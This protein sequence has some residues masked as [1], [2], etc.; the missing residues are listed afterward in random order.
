MNRRL[1][2]TEVQQ[3]NIGTSVTFEIPNLPGYRSIIPVIGNA[4]NTAV[5][6]LVIFSGDGNEASINVV[7][8]SNISPT[9]IIS[10]NQLTINGLSQKIQVVN[11]NGQ[12]SSSGA[13]TVSTSVKSANAF[14]LS[15]VSNVFATPYSVTIEFVNKVQGTIS[16]RIRNMGDN[17]AVVNTE[18]D[19]DALVIYV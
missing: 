15:N 8:P 13:I 18:V 10:G 6:M 14:C 17:S 12:T 11:V 9:S 7:T 19:F 4:N 16:F 1:R 2:V 5:L 3:T